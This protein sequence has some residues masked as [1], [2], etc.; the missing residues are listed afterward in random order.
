MKGNIELPTVQQGKRKLV[1]IRGESEVHDAQGRQPPTH[2][3]THTHTHTPTVAHPSRFMKEGEV[4]L[5]PSRIPHSPNRPEEGSLGLVI[6]RERLE[7][8]MDGMRWYT[9]FNECGDVL[10]E[11]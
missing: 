10:Y 9:N 5:L 2:T 6:E 1:R 4:F 3:R 7:G 11:K 8:E